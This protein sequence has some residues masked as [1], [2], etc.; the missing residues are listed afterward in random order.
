MARVYKKYKDYTAEERR[1]Y[2]R[3]GERPFTDSKKSTTN[4]R[5]KDDKKGTTGTTVNTGAKK[6]TRTSNRNYKRPRYGGDKNLPPKFSRV[7]LPNDAGDLKGAKGAF[8]IT[9]KQ[10]KLIQEGK[11]KQEPKTGKPIPIKKTKKAKE[12]NKAIIPAISRLFAG[13]VPPVE[14]TIRIVKADGKTATPTKPKPKLI[15]Q[16]KKL[17]KPKPKLNVKT[18][19]T[20]NQIKD[21]KNVKKLDVKKLV[22]PKA[23]KVSKA[24]KVLKAPKVPKA[25]KVLKAPKMP[26][27]INIKTATGT[28]I[29]PI[30]AKDAAN[31][32]KWAKKNPPKVNQTNKQYVTQALKAL[33]LIT[34]AAIISSGIGA[35][36]LAMKPGEVAAADN[37]VGDIKKAQAKKRK[38]VGSSMDFQYGGKIP[39]TM[40]KGGKVSHYKHGQSIKRGLIKDTSGG[41]DLVNSIYDTI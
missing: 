20:Q 39:R 21:A 27:T 6:E 38:E 41:Q 17:P 25:P 37:P 31:L 15:T 18:V 8:A 2:V 11:M 23:P 36:F 34:T 22:K 33:V 30:K 32:K 4:I 9:A 29:K 26:K 13:K 40:K 7:V 5:S 3:L 14:K 28:N 35:F 10:Q 1:R 19:Q 16:Q 24:P 12:T